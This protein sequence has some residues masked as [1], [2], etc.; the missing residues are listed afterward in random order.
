[1]ALG[2]GPGPWRSGNQASPQP[3][4]PGL[5]VL[6]QRAVTV[7]QTGGAAAR[8]QRAGPRCTAG[9]PRGHCGHLPTA[10]PVPLSACGLLPSLRAPQAAAAPVWSPLGAPGQAFLKGHGEGRPERS[11]EARTVR[12]PRRGQ[13]PE[14]A[15]CRPAGARGL[16]VQLQTLLSF[17]EPAHRNRPRHPGSDAGPATSPRP[18]GGEGGAVPPA[19]AAP[20]HL[21]K[22]YT[23]HVSAPDIL[24]SN[25]LASSSEKR[26]SLL[27]NDLSSSSRKITFSSLEKRRCFIYNGTFP[28]R[29]P[30]LL[31]GVT[32]TPVTPALCPAAR[33]PGQKQNRS[34]PQGPPGP[35]AG[36]RPGAGE[37]AT[38]TAGRGSRGR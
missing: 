34:S 28:A 15:R 31:S 25:C 2:S 3:R 18:G 11:T 14:Q 20:S 6:S 16:P 13:E 10:R 7:T 27:K 19:P 32:D 38:D 24:L 30:H 17:W 36:R 29:D 26:P 9:T 35:A 23:V 8:E 21:P 37:A 33:S 5:L 1:M 4:E 22:L 12:A